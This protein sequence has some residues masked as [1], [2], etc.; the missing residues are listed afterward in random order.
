MSLT[1]FIPVFILIWIVPVVKPEQMTVYN[2]WNGVPL[3]VYLNAI[4]GT[5]IQVVMGTPFYLSAI[6]SLKH[7]SANMDVLVALGTTSSWLYGLALFLV[8]YDYND[9]HDR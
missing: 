8:G 5:I 9:M 2:G 1:L 4:F 7:R 3:Y 6:K